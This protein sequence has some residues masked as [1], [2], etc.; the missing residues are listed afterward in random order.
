MS[1]PKRQRNSKSSTP[2]TTTSILTAL[3]NI[4]QTNSASARCSSLLSTFPWV[5]SL[6][7]AAVLLIENGNGKDKAH[8]LAAGYTLLHDLINVTS[9]AAVGKIL[10][11]RFLCLHSA[12]QFQRASRVLTACLDVAL[13]SDVQTKKELE[14]SNDVIRVIE[15]VPSFLSTVA[16]CLCNFGLRRPIS[17]LLECVLT[18]FLNSEQVDSAL[19]WSRILVRSQLTLVDETR[20]VDDLMTMLAQ[21]LCRVRQQTQLI[22]SVSSFCD[23]FPTMV[24]KIMNESAAS[25]DV[26]TAEDYN[27]QCLCRSLSCLRLCSAIDTKMTLAS[28]LTSTVGSTRSIGNAVV[29]SF[30]GQHVSNL[31]RLQSLELCCGWLSSSKKC[32]RKKSEMMMMME[33]SAEIWLISSTA[34]GGI[35]GFF[36]NNNDN[37]DD[38]GSMRGNCIQ[39]LRTVLSSLLS[40]CPL[41]VPSIEHTI[42]TYLTKDVS[43]KYGRVLL[44]LLSVPT[45]ARKSHWLQSMP[46]AT[47][48]DLKVRALDV[49]MNHEWSELRQMASNVLLSLGD[50]SHLLPSS[51]S[52][53]PASPSSYLS[54]SPAPP[55]P[56]PSPASPASPASRPSSNA[57]SLLVALE[58]QAQCGTGGE[59]QRNGTDPLLSTMS[60][61]GD[62]FVNSGYYNDQLIRAGGA[63]ATAL[64]LPIEA[65]LPRASLFVEAACQLLIHLAPILSTVH[66]QPESTSGVNSEPDYADPSWITCRGCCVL[67]QR[68]LSCESHHD[69]VLLAKWG[70]VLL[71]VVRR[72]DHHGAMQRMSAVLQDVAAALAAAVVVVVVE[73]ETKNVV[74][75]E[76]GE[77]A[78]GEQAAGEQTATAGIDIV[79]EWIRELTQRAASMQELARIRFSHDLPPCCMAL[80]RGMIAA[81]E[82]EWKRS[83][84]SKFAHGSKKQKKRKRKVGND[85]DDDNGTSSHAVSVT[86]DDVRV[87]TA[88]CLYNLCVQPMLELASNMAATVPARIAAFHILIRVFETHKLR[89]FVL[90]NYDIRKAVELALEC[91]QASVPYALSSAAVLFWSVIVEVMI[92]SAA[93]NREQCTPVTLFLHYPSL[94]D[95]IETQ[96]RSS[97]EMIVA[98]NSSSDKISTGLSTPL[99]LLSLCSQLAPPKGDL[100]DLHCQLCSGLV[101]LCHALLSSPQML[102]RLLAAKSLARLTHP[103]DIK[104]VIDSVVRSLSSSSKLSMNTIHGLLLQLFHLKLVHVDRSHEGMWSSLRKS[105]STAMQNMVRDDPRVMQC[106][107]TAEC[108]RQLVS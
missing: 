73:E 31:A 48:E 11:V 5:S 38:E 3:A 76:R 107:C 53:S 70:R 104:S 34:T 52:S 96:T 23:Q 12:Q 20:D 77:Q 17:R 60:A 91:C 57:M 29:H 82:K 67:M 9:H 79:K 26:D 95:V 80:M 87:T 45:H 37:E 65:L 42:R 100:R 83:K 19:R 14:S 62:I 44:S 50:Y 4:C 21:I 61:V 64:A 15:Q 103:D 93:G 90:K 55:A 6:E 81:S 51:P 49:M 24:W 108:L 35:S 30:S 102:F 75:E 63:I 59:Y 10:I 40:M 85:D 97:I 46:A 36:A 16:L 98:T 25:M 106:S 32:V 69:Q 66:H 7:D 99:V 1:S 84:K 8:I 105:A 92:G 43:L 58:Y 86:E 39:R 47:V 71:D 94:V 33:T 2:T 54:S 68:L 56:P 74:K 101:K 78:G 18:Y 72:T 41:L 88:A 22:Q 13:K 27:D 28:L 89:A